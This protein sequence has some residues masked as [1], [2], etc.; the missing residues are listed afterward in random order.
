MNEL[1]EVGVR[2]VLLHARLR[3][4]P[5]HHRVAAVRVRMGVI[6]VVLVLVLVVT[7][8]QMRAA[9]KKRLNSKHDTSALS[10]VQTSR[11]RRSAKASIRF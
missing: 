11:F 1:V 7:A 6:L 8:E 3:A 5:P 4:T 10:F 9:I 2:L